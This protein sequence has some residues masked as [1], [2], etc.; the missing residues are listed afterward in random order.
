M[1]PALPREGDEVY[2]RATRQRD[3]PPRIRANGTTVISAAWHEPIAHLLKQPCIKFA[4]TPR[5]SWLLRKYP[6]VHERNVVTILAHESI[7]CVFQG[8][9]GPNDDLKA[10]TRWFERRFGS[11]EKSR[12][13]L[14]RGPPR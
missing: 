14:P 10:A 6:L 5:W 8:M 13:L 4:P 11:V 12:G 2:E 7:H 1:I 9:F 3:R